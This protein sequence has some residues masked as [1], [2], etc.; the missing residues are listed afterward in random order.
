MNAAADASPPKAVLACAADITALRSAGIDSLSIDLTMMSADAH[1][2]S[3]RPLIWL[4]VALAMWC[5]C[6]AGACAQSP[7][8]V[9][10]MLPSQHEEEAS[11]GFLGRWA[12][13]QSCG[14]QHSAEIELN[15]AS[16][17]IR[18]AWNDGTR[19]RGDSGELRGLLR[20][21]KLWIRF[22]RDAGAGGAEVCPRFGPERAYFTREDDRLVW[23]RNDGTG[24]Y[25]E[26]LRLHRIIA[27]AQIPTDDHCPE[28]DSSP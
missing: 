22:C 21:G 15:A 9:T 6:M 4:R 16:D 18:G 20:A 24:G 26:Y 17:G 10:A 5:L 28:A 13:T 19:I 8:P 12:Y 3:P 7:G 25:R 27:N 1:A 2:N 11:S 23:Y 14:L